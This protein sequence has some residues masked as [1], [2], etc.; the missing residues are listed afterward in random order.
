MTAPKAQAQTLGVVLVT[1]PNKALAEAIARQL[2]E[3]KLAACVSL[4]PVASI[5]SWQGEVHHDD[6]WQLV[7]KTD[8][9]HF[10]RLEA[11]VRALHPYEVPEVIGLPIACGSLPYL[12]WIAAQT[13]SGAVPEN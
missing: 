4:L 7:I 9:A 5:Y 11:A 8:L 10:D 3:T 12:Q 1:A 13:Q 6:E 2:V